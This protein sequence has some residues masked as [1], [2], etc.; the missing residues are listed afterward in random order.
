MYFSRVY[1]SFL[2]IATAGLFANAKPIENGLAVREEL[3]NGITPRGFPSTACHCGQDLVDVLIDVD[4]KVSLCAGG[5]TGPPS[6]PNKPKDCIVNALNAAAVVIATIK[7]DTPCTSLQVTA[8]VNLLVKIILAIV[9]GCAKWPVGVI[10]AICAA[11]DVCLAAFLK[12]CIDK[13]PEILI[14][15]VLDV[16]LLA[17]VSLCGLLGFVKTLLCLGL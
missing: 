15:I 5:F 14:K 8:A 16:A 17:E 11:L 4:A 7:I 6:D 1:T 10:V 12:A 9:N 2:L 3:N 13:C